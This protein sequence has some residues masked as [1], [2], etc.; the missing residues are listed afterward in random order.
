MTSSEIV[1]ESALMM[2]RDTTSADQR[3]VGFVSTWVPFDGHLK[4]RTRGSVFCRRLMTVGVSRCTG[5]ARTRSAMPTAISRFVSPVTLPSPVLFPATRQMRHHE[6]AIL[7]VAAPH[8]RRPAST[9]APR[10]A[11]A[12]ARRPGSGNA[13]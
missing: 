9:S 13:A 7:P 12:Y 3:L 4:T 1:R 10:H 8:L 5:M 6:T 2:L 11:P